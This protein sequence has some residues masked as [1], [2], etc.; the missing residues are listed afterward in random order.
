MERKTAK[1]E[2][3]NYTR[4]AIETLLYTKAGRLGQD[5]TFNQI[6]DWDKATKLN[7][8]E[9]MF[10]TIQTSFEFVDYVFKIDNVS[11]AF[12][13]Q[14]VR[15]RTA[16]FQQESQR[17]VDVSDHSA[18]L[19]DN[20]NYQDSIQCSLEDYQGLVESGMPIQDAR[21]VLPTAIHTSI[22]M[23]VNLRTLSDMAGTRLCKRTQGEYQEV[24]KKIVAIIL[25]IHPWAE[26]LLQVA[27]VKTGICQ[28]PR[29]TKCPVQKHTLN[30][31]A[32][33]ARHLIRQSWEESN[34]VANPK[35]KDGKTM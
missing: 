25:E 29:Y 17:T 8:L 14:L 20:K 34:H 6:M 28:F 10:D 16:S 22:F 13:H 5:V 35:A 9:Y 24:F 30:T 27:C 23:K 1:I 11:R 2:L 26:P 19:V 3:A 21:G 18:L 32:D 7:H 33:S 31:I 4:N 12:T 15:T